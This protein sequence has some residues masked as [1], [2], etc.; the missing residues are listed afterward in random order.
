MVEQRSVGV[1]GEFESSPSAAA[2]E[3]TLLRCL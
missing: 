2:K 3:L 1:G